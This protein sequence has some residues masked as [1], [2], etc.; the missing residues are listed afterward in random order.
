[1][2]SSLRMRDFKSS[3]SSQTVEGAVVDSVDSVPSARA[4]SVSPRARSVTS[5][6]DGWRLLRIVD[7]ADWRCKRESYRDERRS[8][9]FEGD[10]GELSGLVRL[11]RLR[12]A[13][14]AD[15][16]PVVRLE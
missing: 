4:R 10:R 11:S 14:I 9:L 6:V 13:P 8:S 15:R 12:G 3:S 16:A 7:S 1:M 2:S 5:E